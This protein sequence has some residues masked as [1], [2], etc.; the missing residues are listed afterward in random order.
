MF[1][2]FDSDFLDN[3]T[4]S[5]HA[6]LLP[7]IPDVDDVIL[8][9]MPRFVKKSFRPVHFYLCYKN[10]M[11]KHCV[12]EVSNTYEEHHIYSMPL[13]KNKGS[14]YYFSTQKQFHVSPFFD[15]SGDY[16]FCIT[17]TS[18]K[19]KI[20]ILYKKNNKLVFWANVSGKKYNL[21]RLELLKTAILF[22][23]DSLLIMPRILKEA[24]Y[25]YYKKKLPVWSKPM[26]TSQ[27][28]IRSM[29]MKRFHQKV[30]NKIDAVLKKCLKNSLKITLPN[31][32]SFFY[33]N[34]DTQSQAEINIH[35]TWVF[36]EILLKGEIG[37]GD[38]YI[39][40][41]WTTPN[42]TNVIAF[43]I[44]NKH[45]IDSQFK[46]SWIGKKCLSFLHFLNRNTLKKAS[47][48]IQY[49]YDL[50]NEFYSLFLDKNKQYSSA[51]F[52]SN[53]TTLDDAQSFKINTILKKLDLHQD[54]H[55][56]EIGSGWGGLALNAAKQYGCKVTTITLSKEQKLYISNQIKKESLE[57]LVTV[58]LMDFREL[59]Q[60]YD[61]IVSI[62]M[63]EAVGHNYLPIYFNK[64]K[65]CLKPLGIVVLQAI[66]YPKKEY[67]KYKKRSDFIRKHIFP[68][69][70][71][72]SMEVIEKLLKKNNL[73]LENQENITLSYAKTLSHWY[74]RFTTKVS[75]V[76]AL[77]FDDNFIRKWSYYL[78]Y[79]EAAFKTNYLKTYQLVIKR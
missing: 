37:F 19:L 72:P 16:E 48:N 2:I 33:G 20:T 28:T 62:E 12:A 45:I 41:Y 36:K 39:K 64:I 27:Y 58:K 47:K 52:N 57:K 15:E 54:H 66:T 24:L 56:L 25:L 68:G 1:S 60:Q 29:P 23:I 10:N 30:F 26:P 79:C 3:N 11:L 55:L 21:S 34:I 40:N 65:S 8:I 49:H 4:Q 53:I 22:P 63:I 5:I 9:T 77:G 59:N 6:K 18:T 67:Q 50:G 32:Q 17:I 43:F 71:L 44:E 51:I 13:L 35:H 7:Y 76:K 69:G 14:K 78:N 75:E 31:N 38:A 73:I 61:R 74:N 46:P 42:I 70:H